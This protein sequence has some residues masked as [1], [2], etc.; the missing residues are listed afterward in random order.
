LIGADKKRPITR[1]WVHPFRA[2]DYRRY[3][4]DC[5]QERKNKYLKSMNVDAA[6]LV[7]DPDKIVVRKTG[8]VP[9]PGGKTKARKAKK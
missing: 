6:E 9:R 1:K 5:N 3:F 2:Q 7:H 8:D 4:V